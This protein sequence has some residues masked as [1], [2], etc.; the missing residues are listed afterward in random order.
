LREALIEQALAT[1][2]E[3]GVDALTLRAVGAAI[4]VSRTALYRHF[5]DKSAL[6]AAV[7]REGFQHFRAALEDAWDKK[8]H[9]LDG[10][11]AMGV[12]Y[13]LFAIENPSHFQVMFGKFRDMCASD[14]ALDAD[15]SAAFL[16]LVHA[17]EHLQHSGAI[18][19]DDVRQTA[20]VVWSLVHGIATLAV[21]GQL[22]DA[23]NVEALT[24][25]AVEKLQHGIANGK[26]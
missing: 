17:L 7:A 4:G 3:A 2:R 23:N 14:P 1:I 19:T 21:H 8:G 6:L 11:N 24:R 13:V 5:A 26:S 12:A 15:A 16:V 10:L 25:F 22:R 18:A 20:R 9:N